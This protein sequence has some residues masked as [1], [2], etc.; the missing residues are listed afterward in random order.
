MWPKKRSPFLWVRIGTLLSSGW[1]PGFGTFVPLSETATKIIWSLQRTLRLLTSQADHYPFNTQGKIT[2]PKSCQGELT[3]RITHQKGLIWP[4][5]CNYRLWPR[6]MKPTM[7]PKKRMMSSQALVSNLFP[8]QVG[9]PCCHP[10]NN[11]TF[12]SLPSLCNISNFW[13]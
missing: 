13:S 10:L 5:C 8:F 4:W 1:P 11:E 3:L 6:Q 7:N 2:P 9:L 12:W